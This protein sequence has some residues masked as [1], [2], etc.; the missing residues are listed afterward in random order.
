MLLK[1]PEI[2]KEIKDDSARNID[3]CTSRDGTSR[4]HIKDM[5]EECTKQCQSPCEEDVFKLLEVKHTTK[6]NILDRDDKKGVK[7][8]DITHNLVIILWIFRGNQQQTLKWK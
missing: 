3:R 7:V 8:G 4:N 5:W 2:L 6:M 1:N